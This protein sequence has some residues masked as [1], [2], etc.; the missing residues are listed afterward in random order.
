MKKQ[1]TILILLA[2]FAIFPAL[3][4]SQSTH[5]EIQFKMNVVGSVAEAARIT[6]L[7][8][9]TRLV[10]NHP[11]F[12]KRVRGAWTKYNKAF[13]YSDDNGDQVFQKILDGA[14]LKGPVDNIWQLTYVFKAQKRSCFGVG[15][16]KKC[17]SWVLG[18]TYPTKP[19]IYLNSLPW[20]ERDS[21]GIVG[22]QV[23]E[24]LHK[25]G[26]HHPANN[27]PTRYLSVPYAIGS[28]ASEICKKYFVSHFM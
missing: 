1:F 12:E 5:P 24:Q 21:C 13:S 23:H 3:S 25:F 4:F 6:E 11:E 2:L 16:W 19:E 27:T 17:S 26:Y 14:E 15:R 20:P 7:T 28:L 9:V 10:V 8:E 22:T 18:W